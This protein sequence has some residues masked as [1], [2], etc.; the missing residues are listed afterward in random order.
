LQQ[1]SSWDRLLWLIF[2][3]ANDACAL[4]MALGSAAVGSKQVVA[5]LRERTIS[6]VAAEQ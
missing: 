2:S 5:A 4:S 3:C 1:L 6:L